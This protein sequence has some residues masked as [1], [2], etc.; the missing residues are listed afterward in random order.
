MATVLRQVVVPINEVPMH[1]M[2][3]ALKATE[4]RWNP[5][6]EPVFGTIGFHAPKYGAILRSAY[7]MAEVDEETNEIVE[8]KK[9]QFDQ[10]VRKDGPIDDPKG[11]ATPNAMCVVVEERADGYYVWAVDEWRPVIYDHNTDTQGV[12]V[13]GVTGG[14]AKGVGADPIVTALEEMVA[15][16]GIEIDE[17]SVEEINIHSPNRGYEEAC[18]VVILAKFK[19][20][21]ERQRDESHEVIGDQFPVRLDEIPAAH[22]AL[23]NSAMWAVVRHLDCVSAI[24]LSP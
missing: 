18:N 7:V 23:V 15:E 24:P 6:S 14:W 11:H 12:A 20:K 4:H 21:G 13:V 8:I 5:I 17:S 22:D 19:A 10:M 16:T 9:F 2:E 3:E 1:L